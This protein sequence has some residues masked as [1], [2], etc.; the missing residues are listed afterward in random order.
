MSKRSS[1][2]R[3]DFVKSTAALAVAAPTIISSRALGDDKTPA[4]SNRL[5][6]GFIGIGKQ[7]S[8]HL[9]ALSGKADTQV[10]AVCDVHSGRR[11]RARTV[12]EAKYKKLE[13]PSDGIKE[14]KTYEEL[15]DRKDIDAV[16]IGTPDHWHT[17]IALAAAK[18]GKDIYC[19]KPL[20]LT[21]HEAKTIID[22]VR[23][24]DRVFQTGSQQRSSGPFHQACEYIRNGRI[25]KIKE[26]WIGI[27]KTSKPCDL[28]GQPTPEG[29]DWDQWLGQAPQREWND[30]ICRKESEPNKYPFNPGWRDYREFSGGYITDW[31]AHHFDI[32]QWALDMDHSG[33]VEILPSKQDDGYGAQFIYRGSPVGDEI[34]VT[35]KN[36]V[37]EGEG[38][39][40]KTKTK[41]QLKETNGIQFIGTHGKIFVSRSMI[42]SD[43][44]SVLVEP[45]KENEIHLFKTPNGD[46]RQNWMDCIKTRQKPICDVEIGA[47]SVTVCHLVNLAYW[48][49][50]KFTWDP[51]KW[52]FPGDE[53][54]NKLRTRDRREK[55][56]LPNV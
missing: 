56:P 36:V 30:V 23:K 40:A 35:H 50:R 52:E 11:E 48:H 51:Q 31:G 38:I 18:A 41:K 3:R 7:A 15:L 27:G 37:Y 8:G 49:N 28:P 47:R 29:L 17:A 53:E 54:A 33:P 25:G 16:V 4:P 44:E 14:Y 6:L 19:E 2:T 12:T 45:I 1:L 42:V 5:N 39:D 21:I 43:P 22:G 9:D 13:R 26:V 32:T 46:H 34:L 55:Y 20:T 24:Y 10:L